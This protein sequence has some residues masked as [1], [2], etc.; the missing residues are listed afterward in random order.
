[1]PLSREEKTGHLNSAKL[2]YVYLYASVLTAA[3]LSNRLEVMCISTRPP[4]NS[5]F[6]ALSI[7]LYP[8]N[9]SYFRLIDISLIDVVLI[10]NPRNMTALPYLTE[11]RN[12][13]GLI[14]ATEPVLFI[15]RYNFSH[16]WRE[17]E[18]LDKSCSIWRFFPVT[19]LPTLTPP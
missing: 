18:F 19:W 5:T 12:Y 2:E 3:L 16:S 15:G 11:R 9:C 6:Q 8:A 1:M 13:K 4:S 10:S 7:F 14:L 17:P